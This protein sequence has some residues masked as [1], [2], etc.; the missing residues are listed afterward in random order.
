M[1]FDSKHGSN[2]LLRQVAKQKSIS[3]KSDQRYLLSVLLKELHGCE[4]ITIERTTEP[5]IERVRCAFLMAIKARSS[6]SSTISVE[7]YLPII[8][9]QDRKIFFGSL[10][11]SE[12]FQVFVFSKNLNEVDLSNVDSTRNSRII[13][14]LPVIEG[15]TN[16]FEKFD[17]QVE[18]L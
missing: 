8:N 6:V 3:D 1:G 15:V 17:I 12:E 14:F 4:W 7:M 10:S 2:I 9:G 13:L 18:V 11:L 5:I 16:D